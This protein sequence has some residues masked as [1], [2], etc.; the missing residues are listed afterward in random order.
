MIGKWGNPI[1]FLKKMSAMTVIGYE[2][3]HDNNVIGLT[4]ELYRSIMAPRLKKG[5]KK[6]SLSLDGSH[7]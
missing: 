1:N 4:T 5:I 6:A 7:E 3:F 2:V